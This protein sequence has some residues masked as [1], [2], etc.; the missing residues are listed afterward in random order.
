MGWAM[1][2]V[3]KVAWPNRRIH[4][5]SDLTMTVRLEILWESETASGAEVL[6][7]ERALIVARHAND[8]LIGYN[9][10]PRAGAS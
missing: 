8:P 2:V 5:G 7:K 9:K 3:Y 1:K 10:Q 6:R 4:V